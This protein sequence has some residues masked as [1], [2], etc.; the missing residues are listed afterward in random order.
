[1]IG[2]NCFVRQNVISEIFPT[3]LY[4]P[5][6][7]VMNFLIIQKKLPY[8]VWQVCDTACWLIWR[9]SVCSLLFNATTPPLLK[10]LFQWPTL[11]KAVTLSSLTHHEGAQWLSARVLDLRS[12]GCELSLTG[13]TAMCPWARDINSCL[14]LVQPR[15]THP[16]ITEKLLTGT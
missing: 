11:H 4:H 2:G 10:E 12:S 6:I 13:V 3:S 9:L 1:M 7:W 5:Q 15:K 16:D 8:I 14:V